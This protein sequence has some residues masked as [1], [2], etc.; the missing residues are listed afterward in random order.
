VGED[1]SQAR[2][3]PLGLVGRDRDDREV[4][5]E[6]LGGDQV[7]VDDSAEAG[8][9]PG[10][11]ATCVA[12]SMNGLIPDSADHTR[13]V[14]VPEASFPLPIRT[15]QRTAA[16]DSRAP[17][18]RP[19]M[20]HEPASLRR[21]GKLSFGLAW[22]N[23]GP[24]RSFNSPTS[25]QTAGQGDNRLTRPWR[26]PWSRMPTAVHDPAKVLLDLALSFGLGWGLPG[27]CR[28]AGQEPDTSMHRLAPARRNQDQQPNRERSGLGQ[29]H[30]HNCV[31]NG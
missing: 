16:A 27:R 25:C 10:A 28:L 6:V 1:R 17:A 4:V 30:L 15:V 12:L 22:S 2:P 5:H 29:G 7:A 9:R 21:N 14:H 19:I 18:P 26:Q 31:L 11:A 8:R 23:L 13:A 3:D 20:S 24:G